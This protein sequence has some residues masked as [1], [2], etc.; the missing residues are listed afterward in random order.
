LQTWFGQDS[1][2]EAT[3]LRLVQEA[4]GT[5]DASAAERAAKAYCLRPSTNAALL[6]KALALARRGVELGQNSGFMRYYQLCLGLAEY[7]NGH[8]AAAEQPLTAAETTAGDHNEL[9]GTARFFRVMCLFQEK[10]PEEARKLFSR[11]LQNRVI[12]V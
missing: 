3:R 1:N 9:W 11:L 12:F 8:H 5:D 7:R 10:R 6:A 2:Y 4:E